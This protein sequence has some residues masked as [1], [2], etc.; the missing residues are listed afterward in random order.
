MYKIAEPTLLLDKT[1]CLL[2]IERMVEKAHRSQ[3]RLRPHFKTHQ[4][5]EVG[6]WFREAGVKEITVSSLKMAKY[7]AAD[8]WKDITVAFPVNLLEIDTINELSQRIQLNLLVSNEEVLPFLKTNLKYPTGI[9]IEI[10]LGHHRTG[11]L[12]DDFSAIDRITDFLS[13]S[14]NLHFKG[15]LGHA[16]HTYQKKNAAEINRIFEESVVNFQNLKNRYVSAFPDLI[17]SVGDTPACSF[18]DDFSAFDEIR[19]GNFVFYDLMQWKIGS[20]QLDQIALAMA[21]PVV[22]RYPERGEIFI[23]GG[24]VHFSKDFILM[25]DGSKCFGKVVHLTENG[26]EHSEENLY[27]SAIWQ[28]HGRILTSQGAAKKLETGTLIG[29]LPVHACLTAD[30]MGSYLNILDH[31]RIKMMK[32]EI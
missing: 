16:G 2:N 28:E 24:A 21:C 10:D 4:S 12:P 14:T 18:K 1:K 30:V 7:F 26:W 13:L 22:A 27:L 23:Y 9:F 6:R 11:L 15:F 5:R 17:F 19:P 32:T 3:V 29:I 8:G 31:Q 20:C 25:D